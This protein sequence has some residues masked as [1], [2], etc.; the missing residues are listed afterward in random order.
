MAAEQIMSA[1]EKPL[2]LLIE[3]P[4]GEGKTEAGAYAAFRMGDYFGKR[5]FYVALPTSATANQMYG[6]MSQLIKSM[7]PKEQVR[8]LHST[9]WL[10]DE[11]TQEAKEITLEDKEDVQEWTKPLRRGLL[12]GYS[13]GTIDQVL[14]SAL[15]VKYGVIR[16]L[17]MQNKVLV[18]DEVHAYDAYMQ[19]I[20]LRMLEW[21]RV[22]RIP[23]V[24]LSATLATE[25]KKGIMEV[26]GADYKGE[27][28]Y[29]AI[30]AVF[31]DGRYQVTPVLKVSKHQTITVHIK[32]ILHQPKAICDCALHT[33]QKGGCLCVLVNTVKQAQEI[34]CC[35]KETAGDNTQLYLF[36][37]RFSE[38]QKRKLEKQMIA[39]FGTDKS[40]RPHRAIVVTTQIME[41]SLD[42]DFD[43][44][45]TGIAPIDLLLQRFGRQ[46][47]HE[48]T[49]RPA[50]C[51]NAKAIVLVPAEGED[52]GANEL[53]YPPVLLD[54]SI[55][56]L[57]EHPQLSIPEKIREAVE[58]VYGNEAVQHADMEKWMERMFQEEIKRSQ[59]KNYELRKP[60]KKYFN[61]FE[62]ADIFDDSETS[63]FLSAKTRLTEPT[64]RIA[65][66]PQKLYERVKEEDR[67]SKQLAQE[68]FLHS[69][70]IREEIIKPY[71]ED[72]KNAGALE[73]KGLLKFM[74]I[75][76]GQD[77]AAYINKNVIFDLNEE[78]GFLIQGR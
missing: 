27:Q 69:V 67:V 35:L 58:F 51:D 32:P 13:V 68:V 60:E 25:T 50:G 15:H 5:G 63:S 26:Y 1:D 40:K 33:V 64:K 17:G 34:Y 46:F 49:P 44:M 65:V 8:L 11:A 7:F 66:V 47:R 6:R 12:E 23:V 56:Y 2:L 24:M 52:Y 62:S 55:Q 19:D 73:G 30:T 70:T 71:E 18:L 29:P 75:L 78:F 42:V 22:L 4:M 59:A 36:H 45:I 61:T 53:V 72:M 54:L 57:K 39:L 37:A 14:M 21:C 48:N 31:Q 3:A 38:K 77:G 28:I 9:A 43:F 10:S 16:L 76:P 74:Q 41:Q 20:L